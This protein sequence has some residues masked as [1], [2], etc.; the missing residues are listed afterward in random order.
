MTYPEHA[1]DAMLTK[2]IILRDNP[3]RVGITSWK[4]RAFK[5][6]LA[7]HVRCGSGAVARQC[8]SQCGSRSRFWARQVDRVVASG[9]QGGLRSQGHSRVGECQATGSRHAAV[10]HGMQVCALTACLQ[11]QRDKD[12]AESGRVTATQIPAGCGAPGLVTTSSELQRH[13]RMEEC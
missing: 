4:L 8:E 12:K 2:L 5:P 6:S 11:S 1:S 13:H 3:S 9:P 7:C 10:A